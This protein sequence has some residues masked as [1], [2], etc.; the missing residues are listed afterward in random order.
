MRMRRK[1]NLVARMERVSHLLVPDPYSRPSR[2]R[3]LFGMPDAPVCLELG[4]GKGAF[5]VETARQT[6]GAAFVAVERVPDVLVVAMER[7]AG[8]PNIRF[9]CADAS[10]LTLMFSGG[11]VSR[12]YINFCDPWPASRHIKRRLTS[13]GF[14]DAYRQILAPDGEILF[15]TDNVPLFDFSVTELEA[16]GFILSGV[17][18]NLHENGPVG[19]MTDYE[20]KFHAS[21]LK[22]CSLRASLPE[23]EN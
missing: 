4:C 13:R 10:D 8:L 7:A 6:P 5:T 3:E 16:A 19:V 23:T 14:L 20:A 12:V 15:K 17:T 21:G 9:I 18:K 11:E 1:K 22:I 2:W